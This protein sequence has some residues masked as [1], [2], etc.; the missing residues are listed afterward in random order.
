M[1]AN[2][3]KINERSESGEN[4]VPEEIS[5]PSEVYNANWRDDVVDEA[6]DETKEVTSFEPYENEQDYQ[7]KE[8][9]SPEAENLIWAFD[10]AKKRE[11]GKKVLSLD[12]FKEV[13]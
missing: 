12:V 10:R 13:A 6:E 3:I 7:S 11:F 9:V 4:E 2:N 8:I 1:E 5:L